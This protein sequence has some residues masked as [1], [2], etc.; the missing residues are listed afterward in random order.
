VVLISNLAVHSSSSF[1]NNNNSLITKEIL[2]CG[3]HLEDGADELDDG[4]KDENDKPPPQ[5]QEDLWRPI[6]PINH[7]VTFQKA[8]SFY[9]L[10]IETIRS[11]F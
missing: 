6:S 8:K 4:D 3:I 2:L 7:A 9:K 10:Q 1:L 5:H 11:S